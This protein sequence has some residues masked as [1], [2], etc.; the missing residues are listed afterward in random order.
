VFRTSNSSRT[1]CSPLSRVDQDPPSDQRRAR[2]LLESLDTTLG[3]FD[4][5][6]GDADEVMIGA[7]LT[8]QT[9]WENVEQALD[10]L[11]GEGVC[12]LPAIHRMGADRVQDLIRCTGFFRVKT[13]RLKNLARRVV[14]EY[15][16]T[17]SM[18]RRPTVELREFLLDTHG[19]GEETADSILCYGFSRTSFVVDTYTERICGCAGITAPRKGLKPLFESILPEDPAEYRLVH[20]RFVE[21]AKRWCARCSVERCMV[22]NLPE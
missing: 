2:A 3:T 8:Q 16:T 19:I 20:A 14:E 18:A 10:R 7:V 9:R 17:G 11:R 12:T 22:T 6:P 13:R 21:Y 1:D 4:W 15:G 5:W